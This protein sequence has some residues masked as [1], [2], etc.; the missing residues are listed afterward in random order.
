M[1]KEAKVVMLHA[2]VAAILGYIAFLMQNTFGALGLAVI[3]YFV[4]VRFIR[5]KV[6][7]EEDKNWWIG[8]S[9]ILF[10]LTWLVVWTIFYN[11]AMYNT[12]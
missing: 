3:V 1:D 8:N 2:T 7:I 11:L 12:L 5:A 4:L 6:Q 10:F 9:G